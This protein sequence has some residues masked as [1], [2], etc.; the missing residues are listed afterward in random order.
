MQMLQKLVKM[1]VREA[2][3]ILAGPRGWGDTRDSWLA[4]AASNIE[5]VSFRTLRSLWYGTVRNAEV[6]WAAREVRRQAE[7]IKA[8]EEA[9]KLVA[10]YENIARGLNA[11]DPNFYSEDVAALL[12]AARILRNLDR[13]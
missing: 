9:K 10:Q 7:I 3:S 11:N 2:I 8:R 12:N 13:T 1:S 4:R 5:G 6:H